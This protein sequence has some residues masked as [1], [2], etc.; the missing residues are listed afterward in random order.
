[1]FDF[2]KSKFQILKNVDNI[3]THCRYSRDKGA[4]R[5]LA[6]D[7]DG[8]AQTLMR[9]PQFGFSRDGMRATILLTDDEGQTL[10]M[11]EMVNRIDKSTSVDTRIE[12]CRYGINGRCN[13]NL[14]VKVGSTSGGECA[15]RFMDKLMDHLDFKYGN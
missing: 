12:E 4:I 15:Q 1:M 8:M 7:A 9:S 13:V 14:R 3:D 11:K 6:F 2:L 10:F 5:A